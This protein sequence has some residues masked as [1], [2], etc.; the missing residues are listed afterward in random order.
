MH[1]KGVFMQINSINFINNV[2][3]PQNRAKSNYLQADTI[4]FSGNLI[5]NIAR[6]KNVQEAT[7]LGLKIYDSIRGGNSRK[8]IVPIIQ[9]EFPN[10]K[11]F[12]TTHLKKLI[13]DYENYS[14]FYHAK[15]TSDFEITNQQIFIDL[16][17]NT[18]NAA[19]NL[20]FAKNCAH[21]LTHVKQQRPNSKDIITLKQIS[22]GDGNYAGTIIAIGDLL[23]KNYDNQIQANNSLFAFDYIDTINVAKYGEILP[24][25]KNI[26]KKQFL[27]ANDYSTAQDFNKMINKQYYNDFIVILNTIINN[28]QMADPTIQKEMTKILSSKENINKFYQDLRTYCALNAEKEKEVVRCPF[29]FSTGS[30]KKN[31]RN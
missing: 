9:H 15:L 31:F 14:A 11:I 12:P 23:F 8:D 25:Q 3:K 28:P 21:E 18:N 29:P 17:N 4:S 10:L 6:S 5:S 30:F 24:R 16:D 27:N 13:P 1:Q 20:I 22:N 26:T 7:D 2:S 19:Q